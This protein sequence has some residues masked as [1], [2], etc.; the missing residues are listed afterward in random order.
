MRVGCD[1]YCTRVAPDHFLLL[2]DS[3]AASGQFRRNGKIDTVFV[4]KE[5]G[6]TLKGQK[7]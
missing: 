5:L 3:C 4:L 2:V 7:C 6:V 1:T